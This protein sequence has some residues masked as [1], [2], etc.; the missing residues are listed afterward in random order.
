MNALSQKRFRP[1]FRSRGGV[2]LSRTSKHVL[3]GVAWRTGVFI[4]AVWCFNSMVGLR[5]WEKRFAASAAWG[6]MAADEKVNE[7][8]PIL[9]VISVDLQRKDVDYSTKAA[10]LAALKERLRERPQLW[11]AKVDPRVEAY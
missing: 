10:F 11:N 1:D 7:W 4:V 2:M 5:D 6:K 3:I 9:E 8:S